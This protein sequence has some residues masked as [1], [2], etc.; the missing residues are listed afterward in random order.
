MGDIE[1][2]IDQ[3]SEGLEEGQELEKVNEDD[4]GEKIEIC[5]EEVVEGDQKDDK[6]QNKDQKI[7]DE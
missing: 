2:D 4:L 5:H 7:N 3:E 6:E 1:L